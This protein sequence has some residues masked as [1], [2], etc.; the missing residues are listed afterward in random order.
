MKMIDRLMQEAVKRH[1]VANIYR[2]SNRETWEDCYSFDGEFHVLV[3]HLSPS[4]KS[5]HSIAID[6]YGK[7]LED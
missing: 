1:V 7:V 2:P 5:A 3:Y 4:E 6:I